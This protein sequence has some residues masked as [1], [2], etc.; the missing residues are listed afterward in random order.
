MTAQARL[1][2]RIVEVAREHAALKVRVAEYQR[3]R[4][5]SPAEEV[6]LKTLQRLKLRVKD[7]LAFLQQE[8]QAR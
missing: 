4:F 5:L 1:H 6:E 8:L 3:R 7:T 2:P